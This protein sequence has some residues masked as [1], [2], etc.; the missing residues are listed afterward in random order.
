LYLRGKRN[1]DYDDDDDDDDD[2]DGKGKESNPYL[3]KSILVISPF[4]TASATN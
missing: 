3:D 1:D 2:F 4:T